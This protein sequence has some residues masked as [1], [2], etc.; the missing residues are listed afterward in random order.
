MTQVP[1]ALVVT[2]AGPIFR[3]LLTFVLAALT[4]AVPLAYGV[5]LA[6]NKGYPS[7]IAVFSQILITPLMFVFPL[8]AALLGCLR[9]YAEVGHRYAS[10][11][12]T[13]QSMRRYL[14]GRLLRTAI[15]PSSV[16]FVYAALAFFIAYYVWPEAGNP[17]VDPSF[18]GMTTVQAAQ[19]ELRDTSYSQLLEAGTLAYGLG[20]AVWLGISAGFY[21]IASALCLVLMKNRLAAIALPSALY[22]GQSV[23]AI[24]LIGPQAG[25]VYSVFP[26]GLTQLPIL[27]AAAP[28]LAVD[29]TV[30]VL[31]LYAF[32]TMRRVGYLT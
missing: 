27:V 10:L 18:Y 19:A 28:Q 31:A 6:A 2:R 15:V 16:Y 21:S 24:A 14:V 30:L 3:N 11:V 32:L 25:L 29:V 13:R 9:M 12:G 7:Q 8:I 20:Y 17:G 22:I 1:A 23:L 5:Q 4:V 26:F